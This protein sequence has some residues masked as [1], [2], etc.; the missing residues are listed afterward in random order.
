MQKQ[1]TLTDPGLASVTSPGQ[2]GQAAGSVPG[3][4]RWGSEGSPSCGHPPPQHTPAHP[5]KSS[6]S[7]SSP[8]QGRPGPHVAM[9]TGSG[10]CA[11]AEPCG[12]LARWGEGHAGAKAHSTCPGGR[13]R[14][15]AQLIAVDPGWKSG[16]GPSA[17]R[18]ATHA[19]DPSPTPN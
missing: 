3:S 2:P 6:A 14:A 12:C 17:W 8:E 9:A 10:A 15:G 1:D 18:S 7:G 4:G 19:L 5:R 16:L 11:Q 13:M